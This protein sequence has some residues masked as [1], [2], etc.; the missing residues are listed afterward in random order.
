[1]I[2]SRMPRSSGNHMMD[3]LFPIISIS[4]SLCFFVFFSFL[5]FCF[6]SPSQ[7]SFMLI[8]TSSSTYFWFLASFIRSL[9]DFLEPNGVFLMSYWVYLEFLRFRCLHTRVLQFRCLH[10]RILKFSC[11]HTGFLILRCFHTRVL[12]FRCLHTSF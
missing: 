9:A 7:S 10:I 5:S 8:S 2:S 3:V 6:L 4:L 12:R 1:M 11:L